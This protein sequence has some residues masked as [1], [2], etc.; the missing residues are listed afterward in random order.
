M[1]YKEYRWSLCCD[2]TD[3]TTTFVWEKNYI[4]EDINN[5]FYVEKVY[6]I[7][8]WIRSEIFSIPLSLAVVQH[9]KMFWFCFRRS[10]LFCIKYL[11][12]TSLK[13]FYFK[14]ILVTISR[15]RHVQMSGEKI[16]RNK[17]CERK[18]VATNSTG[19]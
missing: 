3:S 2:R 17:D 8:C 13:V 9:L 7:Y 10:R 1:E 14:Y 6:L 5:N 12:Y 4:K 18:V 11:L 19:L 15:Y 16:I